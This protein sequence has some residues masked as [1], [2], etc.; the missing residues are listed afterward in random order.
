MVSEMAIF[1]TGAQRI[2]QGDPD[3]LVDCYE[4]GVVDGLLIWRPRFGD[5]PAAFGVEGVREWLRYDATAQSQK[6]RL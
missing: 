1:E 5:G 2:G 6:L 4:T 3:A